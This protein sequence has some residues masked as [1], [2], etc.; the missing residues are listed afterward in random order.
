MSKQ[1]SSADDDGRR[2]AVARGRTVGGWE[3]PAQE[4]PERKPSRRLLRSAEDLDIVLGMLGFWTLVLFGTTVWME[5]TGQPALGWALGLLAAV[6]A[7]WGLIR[8]RRR[9]PS[10]AMGRRN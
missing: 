2:A 7:V 9:L 5:L 8:L 6:L 1:Q 4:E 3:G 10:R